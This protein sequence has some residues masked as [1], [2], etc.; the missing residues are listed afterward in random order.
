LGTSH[1]CNG[2]EAVE[3]FRYSIITSTIL[4]APFSNARTAG[5]FSKTA[6]AFANIGQMVKAGMSFF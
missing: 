3:F 1:S 5:Q 2:W 6:I 4:G